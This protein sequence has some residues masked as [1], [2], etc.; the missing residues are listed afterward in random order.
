MIAPLSHPCGQIVDADK[1]VKSRPG[2][3]MHA[4]CIFIACKQV[5]PPHAIAALRGVWCL[6]RRL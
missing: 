5:P 2:S 6:E 3:A 4:S 1:S